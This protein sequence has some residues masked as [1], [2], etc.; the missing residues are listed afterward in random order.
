MMIFV[1]NRPKPTKRNIGYVA[2]VLALFGIKMAYY[3]A[4]IIL[5]EVL[6]VTIEFLLDNLYVI[7]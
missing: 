6:F 5:H 7:F 2:K 3:R 1:P 4:C